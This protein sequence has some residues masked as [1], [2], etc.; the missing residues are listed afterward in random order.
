[1]SEFE[2]APYAEL[3]S[4][5]AQ[6]GDPVGDLQGIE[7]VP[8]AELIERDPHWRQK[9]YDLDTVLDHD[10]PRP[11]PSAPTPFEQYARAE[12]EDPFFQ[13]ESWFI[14]LDGEKYIGLTALVK[15]TESLETLHTAFTGV[16]RPYRRRGLAIA[17]KVRSFQYARR[18]GTRWILTSNEENNPMYKLN[19]RLGFRPQPADVDWQKKL[20]TEAPST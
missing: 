17:L 20:S 13:P 2:P 8:L 19:L 5:L 4:R 9:V 12:F 3:L 10:V 14:A 16:L 1:L 6:K 15:T 11:Q 7:I 18:M